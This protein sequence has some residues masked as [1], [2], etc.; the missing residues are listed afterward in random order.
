[1][2]FKDAK[3]YDFGGVKIKENL[4]LG[5]VSAAQVS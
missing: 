2:N 1:M 4:F 5:D 3:E